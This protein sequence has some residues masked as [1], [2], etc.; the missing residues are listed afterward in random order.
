MYLLTVAIYFN[1]IPL[2]HQRV[3][4]LLLWL[5]QREVCVHVW[6]DV[7]RINGCWGLFPTQLK[8]LLRNQ[9]WMIGCW[10]HSC[11]GCGSTRP[12]GTQSILWRNR[13]PFPPGGY[14]PLP[15]VKFINMG[16]KDAPECIFWNT[17]LMYGQGWRL[18][19]LRFLDASIVAV[20]QQNRMEE[21]IWCKCT[22]FVFVFFGSIF[23]HTFSSV[24]TL[25]RAF[26]VCVC[27]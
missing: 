5:L 10:L 8:A 19:K 26:C 7:Q 1:M 25:A 6:S 2:L 23:F 18:L 13:L 4:Q 21:I 20:C 22:S 27:V 12:A 16:T 14:F 24:F 11:C 15:F 17:L 9:M 3:G